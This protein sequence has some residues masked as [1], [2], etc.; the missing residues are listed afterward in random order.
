MYAVLLP[1]PDS[2][3]AYKPPQ[4]KQ[5]KQMSL[6]VQHYWHYQPMRL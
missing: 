3:M 2:R 4:T 1:L 6:I 5:I